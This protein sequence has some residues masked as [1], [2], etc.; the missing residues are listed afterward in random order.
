VFPLPSDEDIASTIEE[1]ARK[2]DDVAEDE[3]REE[4]QRYL[5]HGVPLH[6]AKRDLEQTLPQQSSDSSGATDPSPTEDKKLGDITT[7]DENVNV[8][9]KVLSV[10]ERQVTAR[11]EEKTIW[12]GELGDETGVRDYTSWRNV[13]LE[14][15]QVLE[16][17]NAY[18]TEWRDAPQ[19]NVGDHA[20]VTEIADSIEVPDDARPKTAGEIGELEAGM[21]AVTIT[22][23]VLSKDSREV[24]VRGE[25]QTLWEGEIADETGRIPYTAWEEFDFGEDDVLTIDN[26]YVRSFRGVPQLNFGDN[27]DVT[28]ADDDAVPS[29]AEL[30]E[31]EGPDRATE[32]RQV[33][34]LSPGDSSVKLTGRVLDR[35]E[36]EITSDGETQTLWEGEIAD[37]TGRIPYTAWEEFDFGEGDVVTIDNAY[38]RSFRG[39]PQLNFGD[40]ADVRRGD[41]DALP[42]QTEL[43][44]PREATIAELQRAQGAVGARLEAAVIEIRDGSGLIFRCPECRRVLREGEC[45]RHGEVDGIADLRIKAV[46]DDGTGGLTALFDR[47]TTERLLDLTLEEARDEARREGAEAIDAKLAEL[48]LMK[49]LR[50]D[51]NATHDEY[52][53]QFV[54]NDVEIVDHGDVEAEAE[55]MIDEVHALAEEVAA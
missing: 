36:R 11:G 16:I 9:A 37:E 49:P 42:P 28:H 39:L 33:R 55:Q 31:T 41:D 52:G 8:R 7:S 34:D 26:A 54:V 45:N 47:P 38:V 27:A 4:L 21:S 48:I 18:V 2:L 5:D 23:R 6:Q 25:P 51:G 12:S 43:A 19:I 10:D 22:G 35:S 3:I 40:N 50:L 53:T 1:L 46:V 44:R 13:G 30:A 32:E 14:E 29:K 24:E 20:E 17:E 15:G